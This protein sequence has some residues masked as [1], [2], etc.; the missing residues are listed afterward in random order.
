MPILNALMGQEVS[1]GNL[2]KAGHIL[3]LSLI[4]PAGRGQMEVDI[5]RSSGLPNR[6]GK[7]IKCSPLKKGDVQALELNIKTY[8]NRT[9]M[10]QPFF[11]LVP[12]S[13]QL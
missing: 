8:Q 6:K 1:L 13:P 7:T 12:F 4:K 9:E 11:S 3:L 5:W 10:H 2:V